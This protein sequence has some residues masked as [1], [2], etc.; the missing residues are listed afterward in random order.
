[1]PKSGQSFFGR[2]KSWA[3]KQGLFGPQAFFR[4]VVFTYVDC[5][6]E[7][8]D[9]FIC[10]G[11]NL[12]WLYI[13]TPRQTVDLDL[14][15]LKADTTER[16]KALLESGGKRG[17]E[18]GIAF[19]LVSLKEV[20]QQGEKGA[21]ATMEYKTED[22]AANTFDLDIV[23]VLPTDWKTLPSPIEFGTRIRGATLEHIIVDKIATCHRF[24]GG[25]TRMKDFD[26]LWRISKSDQRIDWERVKGGLIK[27]RLPAALNEEWINVETAAAWERHIKKYKDLPNGLDKVM[28]AV[29]A[30]L[31][32]E[33]G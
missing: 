5:L 14:V 31:K 18:K 7:E 29:N 16:V 3:A 26:D 2:A 9:D 27:H 30:W 28:S 20:S 25:N 24:G 33:V 21:S 10:K 12:L 11:G 6:A 17:K 19:R 32:H 15:T 23:Y 4:Y 1:V 8:T 13:H 22:G